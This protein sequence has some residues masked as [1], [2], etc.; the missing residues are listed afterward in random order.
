[1]EGVNRIHVAEDREQWQAFVKT[2]INLRYLKAGGF[3]D[4]C[5]VGYP[6]KTVA[7]R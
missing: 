6:R 7:R 3:L 2:V 5:S 4:C 1:L